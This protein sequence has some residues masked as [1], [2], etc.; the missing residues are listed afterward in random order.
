MVVDS[1]ISYVAVAFVVE[2]LVEYFIAEWAGDKAKYAAAAVGVLLAVGFRMDLF[3]AFLGLGSTIPYLGSVITG[4]VM[5]RG[6]NFVN[7]FTDEYL[8][9]EV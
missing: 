8:R 7:D 1:L 5:G 9:S 4:L 3:R 6:A 2:A